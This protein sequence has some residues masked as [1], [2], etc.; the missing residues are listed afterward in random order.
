MCLSLSLP[1]PW[2]STE[3]VAE[4]AETRNKDSVPNGEKGQNKTR[5]KKKKTLEEAGAD[6]NSL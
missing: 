1:C 6:P 3:P 2:T 4:E 5:L